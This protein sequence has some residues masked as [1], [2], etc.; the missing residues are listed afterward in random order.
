MFRKS[1]K[2]NLFVIKSFKCWV[3]KSDKWRYECQNE[4]KNTFEL[5]SFSFLFPQIEAIY[6]TQCYENTDDDNPICFK[7]PLNWIFSYLKNKKM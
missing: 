4:I 2:W 6:Q 7:F 1:K 3:N 5:G